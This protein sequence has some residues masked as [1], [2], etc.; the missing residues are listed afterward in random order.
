M[1]LKLAIFK[2]IKKSK[3]F[4]KKKTIISFILNSLFR[5]I[6]LINVLLIFVLSI[7]VLLK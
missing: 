2:N 6:L 3:S 5:L 7:L 4:N 1:K